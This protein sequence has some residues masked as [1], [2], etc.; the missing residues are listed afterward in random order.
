MVL[1]GEAGTAREYLEQTDLLLS[2]EAGIEAMLK[3]CMASDSRRD[4]VNFLASYLMR[5]NPRTNP[6]AAQRIKEM[7]EKGLERDA[8]LAREEAI[9]EE[10]VLKLAMGE[11]VDGLLLNME[12]D[13]PGGD[14]MILEVKED[15]DAVEA[16]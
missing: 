12:L 1:L 8:A 16:S 9:R 7:R 11:E 4:P 14:K 10:N 6:E 13:V 3:T 5:N 2:L 15:K